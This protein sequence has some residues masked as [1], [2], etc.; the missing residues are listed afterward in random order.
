MTLSDHA[1]DF[2]Y[3]E[4]RIPKCIHCGAFNREWLSRERVQAVREKMDLINFHGMQSW[5]EECADVLDVVI[6]QLPQADDAVAR[7]S[8]IGSQDAPSRKGT[9]Q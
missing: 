8:A 6:S 3:S 7:T 2:G 1:C 9:S 4:G 5:S